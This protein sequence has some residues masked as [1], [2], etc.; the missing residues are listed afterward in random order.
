MLIVEKRD[1]QRTFYA[2]GADSRFMR[3]VFL[4][5]GVLIAAIG[6]A[7]G[8][9]IGIVL[10]LVQQH[11]GILKLPNEN[12]LIRHYPIELRAMDIVVIVITLVA[13]T[14]AVS[15]IATRTMIKSKSLCETK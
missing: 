13:V 7:I 10:V 8:V 9:A 12:F 6:G 14:L 4:R 1:E 15:H 5:E 2:L 3:G 11:F